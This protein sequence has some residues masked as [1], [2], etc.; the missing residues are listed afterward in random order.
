MAN[1]IFDGNSKVYLSNDGNATGSTVIGYG[2]GASIAAGDNYNVFIG[3]QVADADMTLA[4]KNIGMG[5]FALGALT[6]GDGNV[7]IGYSAG[8]TLTTSSNNILIGD[9]AGELIAADQTTTDGTVAIGRSAGAALTSGAANTF[10][11]FE[12]GND[13][14]TG[15]QNIAIGYQAFDKATTTAEWNVAIGNGAMGGNIG[16]DNVDACVAIGGTTMESGL[17][18]GASGSVAVGYNA[19]ANLTDN[20]ALAI[21]YRAGQAITTGEGNLAVGYESLKTNQDGDHCTA[22][23]TESLM[24]FNASSSGDG[25]NTALGFRALKLL[26]NGQRNTVMGALAADGITQGTDN[27][28]IGSSALG[29]ATTTDGIA[30]NV[31]IGSYTMDGFTTE[32]VHSSIGIGYAAMSGA[33]ED[34]TSGSIGI[35]RAA[36]GGL[37]GGAGNVAIGFRAGE[38]LTTGASNTIIGHTAFTAATVDSNENVVIG[39]AAAASQA[40][41]GTTANV[42]IGN[43]AGAGGTGTMRYSVAIGNQAL[44][45]TAGNDTDGNV[46]IGWRAGNGI[47]Q[48]NNNVMIGYGAGYDTQTLTTG[49]GNTVI[50]VNSNTSAND[51]TNEI[52]IGMDVTGNANDSFTFGHQASDTTCTNGA[53]SWSNPSDVRIKKDIETSNVGLSMVNDLRPVN[54]KFKTK[55]EVDSDFYLYEKD[56][57]ESAGFTDETVL[58]FVAQEVKSVID[59]HAEYKG[60]ELWSEGLE[61]HDKRQRI[62]QTALIPILTK[63][64]QELSTELEDL[65]KKGG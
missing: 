45:S 8:Y 9:A 34:A 14:T 41:T 47:T 20:H 21:G 29:G 23:G 6:T 13:M 4:T 49:T 12:A 54:F 42:I 7:A 65:K 18:T 44:Q 43:E 35:G 63:A 40:D 48:G 46:C 3:H 50:G 56:S 57:N 1:V 62:S 55:G 17:A 2:A 25:N 22:V 60:S 27:V 30:F 59:N 33:L 5:A 32:L 10:I 28:A 51:S 58:G 53:T 39:Y 36:L 61:L 24:T 11:G 64:I 31:A 38:G 37:T 19:L 52:V 26:T 16:T 15:S